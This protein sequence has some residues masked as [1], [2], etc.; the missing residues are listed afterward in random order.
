VIITRDVFWDAWKAGFFSGTSFTG[1]AETEP[2]LES[3]DS[4]SEE[5][6]DPTELVSDPK[7]STSESDIYGR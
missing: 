7:V 4:L 3:N 5:V 2:G 1:C 6:Q